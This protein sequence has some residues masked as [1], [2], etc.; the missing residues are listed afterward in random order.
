ML[1][2]TIGKVVDRVKR[3]YQQS[4]KRIVKE[5]QFHSSPCETFRTITGAQEECKGGERSRRER[6]DND[7]GKMNGGKF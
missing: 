7:R 2:L 3:N 5:V 1:F 6:S 4:I